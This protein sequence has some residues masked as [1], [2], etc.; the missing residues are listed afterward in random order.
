MRLA[1]IPLLFALLLAVAVSAD[2]YISGSGVSGPLE[3]SWTSGTYAAC[4]AIYSY[5]Y[6]F[7]SATVIYLL[8][9]PTRRAVVIDNKCYYT[10]LAPDGNGVATL[11]AFNGNAKTA[12]YIVIDTNTGRV[13]V[14][15]FPY[16]S[17]VVY[18]NTTY[19]SAV[20]AFIGFTQAAFSLFWKAFGGG[21]GVAGTA[22]VIYAPIG[23]GITIYNNSTALKS[24]SGFP[25]LAVL[26]N[27]TW[28]HVTY[29]DAFGNAFT[30]KASSDVYIFTTNKYFLASQAAQTSTT[31]STTTTTTSTTTTT[32]TTS[33]ASNTATTTTPTTTPASST[34]GPGQPIGTAPA[35]QWTVQR[36]DGTQTTV[37]YGQATLYSNRIY[38]FLYDVWG[39]PVTDATVQCGNVAARFNSTNLLYYCDGIASTTTVKVTHPRYYSV[40]FQ[41]DPGKIYVVMLYP[42][43]SGIPNEPTP[44]SSTTAYLVLQNPSPQ[45][46]QV[47]VQAPS[48]CAFGFI[49]PTTNLN[50]Y[51]LQPYSTLMVTI[52]GPGDSG[53]CDKAEISVLADGKQVWSATWGSIKG[54][55]QYI[56]VASNIKYPVSVYG[57]GGAYVGNVTGMPAGGLLSGNMLQWLLILGGAFII[58][59]LLAVVLSRR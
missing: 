18:T 8:V 7:S 3:P 36:P 19:T 1:A 44:S 11:V 14:T 24:S 39:N 12:Y 15:A 59:M 58:L 23:N 52:Q 45:T 9:P 41:A 10:S 5:R 21:S 47:Q 6:D 28:T 53:T 32:P 13:N 56:N 25:F 50:T 29:N 51:T 22:A 46:V 48:G 54:T 31:T 57:N 30:V 35:Q 42:S 37:A 2:V 20:T 4:N 49:G 34:S 27:T 16:S 43:T 40:S 55:T 17:L 33:T 38:V 26:L